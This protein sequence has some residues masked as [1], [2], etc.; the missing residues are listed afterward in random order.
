MQKSAFVTLKH[1]LWLSSWHRK[2]QL[3]FRDLK[4]TDRT[5][6]LNTFYSQEN[7]SITAHDISIQIISHYEAKQSIGGGDGQQKSIII[8][9]NEN[10]TVAFER[11]GHFLVEHTCLKVFLHSWRTCKKGTNSRE[12]ALTSGLRSQIDICFKPTLRHV[13][14]I[15][16]YAKDI[17]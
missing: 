17:L 16:R 6:C 1:I 11:K 3:L 10:I 14:L 4:L 13:H 12:A 7:H 8:G 5:S 9:R 2:W 15:K